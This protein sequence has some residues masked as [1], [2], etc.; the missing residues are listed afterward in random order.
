MTRQT[1][2]WL[3]STGLALGTV[4]VWRHYN[5]PHP[6]PHVAV[7]NDRS[8]SL[9]H[10]CGAIEAL[11][12]RSLKLP[13]VGPKSTLALFSTTDSEPT[14]VATFKLPAAKLTTESK[15]KQAEAEKAFFADLRHRCE[16]LPLRQTSP[17]LRSIRQVVSH[18]KIQNRSPN[19]G[20]YLI[21]RTDLQET[22]DASL[23][24]LLLQ[25]VGTKVPE[26]ARQ[27]D[28][29]GINVIVCGIAEGI[30]PRTGQSEYNIER[31]KEVWLAL[32]NHPELVVLEPYCPKPEATLEAR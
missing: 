13:F 20:H 27:I 21:A 23:K 1:L 32:F 30:P 24:R 17:L 7:L 14:F 28:N 12:Q 4:G 9:P 16:N 22:A 25:P 8:D 5:P 11:G 18:L 31:I 29:A 2:L 26:N 15:R 6:T 3:L 19:A 10:D